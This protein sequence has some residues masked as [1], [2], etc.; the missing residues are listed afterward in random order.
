[1][2]KQKKNHKDLIK[3]ARLAER[4]MP[5]CLRADLSAEFEEL[6]RQLQAEQLKPARA[7]SGNPEARRISQ[8]LEKLREQMAEHELQLRL[9]AIPQRKYKKLIGQYPPQK[10]IKL[11]EA[12]GYHFDG[13]VESLIRASVVEPALDDDDWTMLLGDDDTDGV[14]TSGQYDALYEACRDLNRGNTTVP[15]SRAA[16][17]IIHGSGGASEQPEA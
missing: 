8:E 16:Y 3:G 6:E 9:R 4:V 17:A 14:L 2:S 15:F 10:G 12:V 5:V 7:L 11:D 13:F 1:M